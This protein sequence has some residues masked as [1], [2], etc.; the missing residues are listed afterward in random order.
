MRN[1]RFYSHYTALFSTYETR[2]GLDWR[3]IWNRNYNNPDLWRHMSQ[4]SWNKNGS[5]SLW[6]S[7]NF[8]II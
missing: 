5:N 7:K 8:I 6:K 4:T 3:N 2:E 1:Q